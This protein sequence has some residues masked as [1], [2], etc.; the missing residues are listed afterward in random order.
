MGVRPRN[1]AVGLPQEE[2]EQE[3]EQEGRTSVGQ[4]RSTYPRR[5]N[6]LFRGDRHPRV[7][8]VLLPAL[9]V[10][11]VQEQE[12]EQEVLRTMESRQGSLCRDIR[13]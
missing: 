13:C 8:G 11:E 6:R 1:D 7:E 12:Q 5:A 9:E 2:Q 10:R 4:E 3:G